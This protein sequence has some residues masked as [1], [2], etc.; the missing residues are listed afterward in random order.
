MPS[1]RRKR[2]WCAA[3][4]L[5]L[6]LMAGLAAA[7]EAGTGKWIVGETTGCGTSNPFFTPGERIRWHGTCADGKLHGYGTLIWIQDDRETERNVGNFRAGEF[8]GEVLTTYPDGQAIY[9]RYVDGRRDGTFV[10]IRIDGS[11]VEASYRDGTLV[12]QRE[13]TTAAAATWRRQREAAVAGGIASATAPASVPAPVETGRT[14]EEDEGFFSGWGLGDWNVLDRMTGWFGFDDDAGDSRLPPLAPLA[15]VPAASPSTA[16][17]APVTT[18]APAPVTAAAGT[19]ATLASNSAERLETAYV[20]TPAIV[21]A[22][23]VSVPAPAGAIPAPSAAIAL[24]GD[25]YDMEIFLNESQSL[26]QHALGEGI[27][28]HRR[29]AHPQRGRRCGTLSPGGRRST[30]GA[31]CRRRHAA[32]GPARRGVADA[33]LRDPGSTHHGSAERVRTS[34]SDRPTGWSAAVAKTRRSI[35]TSRS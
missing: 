3:A 20:P 18:A 24:G 5:G 8:H 26:R 4:V 30:G 33:G 29:L 9:G 16:A 13:M 17:P 10:I 21:R 28:P 15:P 27:H 25:W 34:C 6:S 32:A 22:P 11:H 35:C 31:Q 7:A 14:E 2:P 19:R 1:G 23:A 12:S